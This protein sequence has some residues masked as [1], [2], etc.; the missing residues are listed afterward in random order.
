MCMYMYINKSLSSP[1]Q[2]RYTITCIYLKRCEKS[3]FCI[4]HLCEWL[5]HK[6]NETLITRGSPS[7]GSSGRCSCT[8]RERRRIVGLATATSAAAAQHTT[9]T[10]GDSGGGEKGDK[11]PHTTSTHT[12]T[13]H[14]RTHTHTMVLLPL[15]FSQV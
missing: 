7:R 10:W 3:Y 4:A 14:A 2:V 5:P 15:S 6:L 13:Q 12:H 11:T 9:S 8:S 1:Y